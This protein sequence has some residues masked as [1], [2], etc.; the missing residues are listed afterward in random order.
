[1]MNALIYKFFVK[2][3]D[4]VIWKPKIVRKNNSE[5]STRLDGKVMGF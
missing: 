3:G 2:K 5:F 1:M 4:C